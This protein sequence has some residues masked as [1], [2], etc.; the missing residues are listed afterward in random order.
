[1][2]KMKADELAFE[3]KEE[4]LCYEQLGEKKAEEWAK[5]FTKWLADKNIKKKNVVEKGGI[6]YYCIEDES[7]VFDIADEYLEA[8][9]SNSE[10]EYWKH[11]Q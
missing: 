4:L 1:M 3:V 6:Q 10:A 8:V 5:G 11:F 2:I 9:E 7:A